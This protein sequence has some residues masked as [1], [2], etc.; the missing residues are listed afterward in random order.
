MWDHILFLQCSDKATYFVSF[1]PLGN[2]HSC[3]LTAKFHTL[4]VLYY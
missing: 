4:N 1:F 3:N 2:F